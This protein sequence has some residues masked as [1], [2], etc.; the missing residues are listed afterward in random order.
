VIPGAYY[1]LA[2][3]ERFERVAAALHDACLTREQMASAVAW[4]D[5]A[6]R[7]ADGSSDAVLSAFAKVPGLNA[8]CPLVPVEAHERHGFVGLVLALLIAGATAPRQHVSEEPPPSLP[9]GDAPRGP[10]PPETAWMRGTD[11][12]E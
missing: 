5:R 3:R 12:A 4:L 1:T 2:T 8:M 7:D 6:A 11:S 10:L 9:E